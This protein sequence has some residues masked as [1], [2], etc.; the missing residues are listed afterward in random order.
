MNIL[1]IGDIMGDSGIKVV[2]QL[3]PELKRE[4]SIDLVIAQAENVSDGKSMTPEDMK[5]LQN[6]GVDFFTGGN[7]TP[8]REELRPLIEDNS[9]PVIAPANMVDAPGRGWKYFK[10]PAGPVLIISLLGE[11]FGKVKVE[12]SNPLLKIDEILAENEGKQRIATVVN[13]HGDYSSEKLVMGFY[14]DGKVTAV[15]GDHWHVATADAKLL[16]KGTA[17]ITDVGMCGSQNSCLGVKTEIIIDRW[18]NGT[19]NKN[20]LEL[21]GPLQFNAVLVKVNT[22]TGLADSIEQITTLVK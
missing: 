2:E 12:I 5:M 15:I 1:Y 4:K 6:I 13:I 17:H 18:R 9:Q 16:P 22:R 20:E 8:K 11:T 14:L 3:L 19:L 21:E 10:T 7:H